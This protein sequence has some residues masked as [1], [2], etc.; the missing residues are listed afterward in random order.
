[1]FISTGVTTTLEKYPYAI[2]QQLLS[3]LTPLV[4]AGCIPLKVLFNQIIGRIKIKGDSVTIG[5]FQ[6][7]LSTKRIAVYNNLDTTYAYY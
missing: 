1:M 6:D 5:N 3:I 2:Y 7:K 4:M